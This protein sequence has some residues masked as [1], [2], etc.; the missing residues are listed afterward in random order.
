MS[1]VAQS[2]RPARKPRQNFHKNR[3]YRP[4]YQDRESRN[5]HDSRNQESRNQESRNQES[6]PRS[7]HDS[8]NYQNSRHYNDSRNYHD[9]RN[10]YHNH[11]SESSSYQSRPY[12]RGNGNQENFQSVQGAFFLGN[13]DKQLTREEVYD[14]IKNETCCYICKF[15]MPNVVGNE[16]D[17]E[18]RQIR[19][20]GFAFVHVKHQWMADRMLDMGKIRIGN[21]DAEVKPYDQM[22]RE[23]SERRYRQSSSQA[24]FSVSGEV[25]SADQLVINENLDAQISGIQ[26]Q[27]AG[28]QIINSQNGSNI[29][30]SQPND[31]S[32]Q[33]MS[34][35]SQENIQAT[36]NQPS[37]QPPAFEPTI[38]TPR[39]ED[40]SEQDNGAYNPNDYATKIGQMGIGEWNGIYVEDDSVYQTEDETASVLS[41]VNVNIM[42]P[43]HS[44]FSSRPA[45]RLASPGNGRRMK[46]KQISIPQNE[47]E[48]VGEI[49]QKLINDGITPT[50]DKINEIATKNYNVKNTV[51]QESSSGKRE[52]QETVINTAVQ[53]IQGPNLIMQTPISVGVPSLIQP[54]FVIPSSHIPYIQSPLHQTMEMLSQQLTSM[55]E[56]NMMIYAT[57][58]EQWTQ[59]YATNPH[60]IGNHIQRSQSEQEQFMVQAA[61]AITRQ[62]PLAEQQII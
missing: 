4:R 49:T 17:K 20:A 15:D 31:I 35:N 27:I 24:S 29:Q 14:F 2:P 43:S 45:S 47:T 34:S 52:S 21:L 22:K 58:V 12:R 33:N 46:P 40:W 56:Y 13:V 5:N 39:G 19:C 1:T 53:T 32:N 54:S 55:D 10:N 57:L 50:A 9:S 38:S 61:M 62:V 48:I 44:N 37:N 36:I 28:M 23:M 6:Q 41:A 25:F 7:H 18:G 59:F 8:R 26:G 51:V 60:E 42:D 30:N 11:H 3:D 16:V